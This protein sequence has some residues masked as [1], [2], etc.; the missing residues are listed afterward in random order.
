M[1]C[2]ICGK[3]NS[4]SFSFCSACGA[5]LVVD[6]DD[7]SRELF[8]DNKSLNCHSRT[9]KSILMAC[10]SLVVLVSALSAAK[11]F[12]GKGSN[13]GYID[14]GVQTTDNASNAVDGTALPYSTFPVI[15]KPTPPPPSPTPTAPPPNIIKPTPTPDAEPVT[16][17]TSDPNA[18]MP[19]RK[20]I[21]ALCSFVLYGSASYARA[22]FPPE[23]LQHEIDAYGS[24]IHLIGGEDAAI[25]MIGDMVV[26]SFEREYGSISSITYTVLQRRV[27]TDSELSELCLGLSDYGMTSMPVE[28]RLLSLQLNIVSY[29]GEFTEFMNVRVLLI[30]GEWYIHPADVDF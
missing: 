28:A 11:L 16:V 22:A 4:D 29:R 24:A 20:P 25:E 8:C 19:D 15:I 26:G 30:G 12:I 3:E 23:Y 18:S 1:R 5:R 27:Y 10:V 6:S 7:H 9:A 2:S 21:D 17:P 14:N 13:S